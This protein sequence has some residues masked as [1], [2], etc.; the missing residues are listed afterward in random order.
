MRLRIHE[1][2]EGEVLDDLW[3]VARQSL[4]LDLLVQL[5]IPDLK[6]R[7]ITEQLDVFSN[8]ALVRKAGGIKIRPALSQVTGSALE[9]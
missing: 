9:K 3:R 6:M 7:T 8:L 1:S 4:F 2:S 5:S